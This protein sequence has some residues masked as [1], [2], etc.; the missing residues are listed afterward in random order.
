M[1]T[2]VVNPLPV[3]TFTTSKLTGCEPLIVTFNNT[4]PGITSCN[5]TMNPYN[6]GMIGCNTSHTFA[7]GNYNVSLSVTDANGC[8]ATS[9][10]VMINVYTV[11]VASFSANP[12]TT[13]IDN[14]SVQFTNLSTPG[15]NMWSF[16]DGG[17]SILTNPS[18]TYNNIGYYNVQL[19]VTT[20]AGCQ[21]VAT[22]IIHIKDI[23]SFWVPNAFTPNDSGVNDYFYPVVMGYKSYTMLIFNRWG[24]QIYSGTQEGKWD[25]TYKNERVK[26]D[27]YVWKIDVIDL[28]G[29]HHEYV[30]HVTIIK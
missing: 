27:V 10:S 19:T 28:D 17:T 3:V 5:W 2:S 8:S 22:G 18:H 11:P 29:V 25:G 21:A 14:S 26:D 15:A 20:F 13:D 7:T 6:G 4:T 24:E 9:S 1:V 30:G 16:G 12:T 23:Y